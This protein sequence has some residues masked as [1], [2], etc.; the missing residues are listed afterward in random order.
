MA[1]CFCR[2][3][4]GMHHTYPCMS[5]STSGWYI[6]QCCVQSFNR[7]RMVSEGQQEVRRKWHR[8]S[9]LVYGN[10]SH[11]VVVQP[12]AKSWQARK[13]WLQWKCLPLPGYCL[14][15]HL[16]LS[17][18]ITNITATSY[19]FLNEISC[20]N[21]IFLWQ[22]YAS[23]CIRTFTKYQVVRGFWHSTRTNCRVT[24]IKHIDA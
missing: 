5:H 21:D 14:L 22:N 7:K 1:P 12:Q 20:L 18:L 15:E 23:E 10:H 13:E 17:F 3:S 6:Y 4:A 9:H 11:L 8:I 19:D 16:F 2:S 24:S